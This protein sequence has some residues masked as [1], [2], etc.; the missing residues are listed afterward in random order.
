MNDVNFALDLYSVI[1]SLLIILSIRKEEKNLSPLNKNLIYMIIANAMVL[2]IDMIIFSC[3][4]NPSLRILVYILV[5]FDYF[6]GFTTGLMF[7]SYLVTY[8]KIKNGQNR[9]QPWVGPTVL[10]IYFSAVLSVIIS[11]FN[12]MYFTIDENSNYVRSDTFLFSHIFPVLMIVLAVVLV[13]ANK[14]VLSFKDIATLSSYA[15]MP[16]IALILQMFYHEITFVYFMNTFAFSIVH[17]NI[18]IEQSKLLRQKE[19]ELLDS[20]VQVMLSQIQPHFLYNALTAISCLC[21]KDPQKAKRATIR[22]SKYL[23]VNLD[24]VKLNRLVTFETELEHIDNYVILEK[25]RFEDEL[26][27]EYEIHSKSFMIPV[28][29]V[30]PLVENAIKYNIGKKPEL[31][32]VVIS[33]YETENYYVVSVKDNGIGFNPKKI[34]EDHKNHVGLEN[35]EQRLRSFCNGTL[36]IKS[37]LEKGTIIKLKIPKNKGV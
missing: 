25:M 35:T 29:S 6:F 5:V 8:I 12:N 1:F 31:F 34:K 16:I 11:L 23:R 24:S 9:I 30:Q 13:I 32:T 21:D 22:F 7:V 27:V 10:C 36:E 4:G 2:C 17:I 19:A 14:R 28:L 20:K 18:N 33:S 3:E 26:K 15:I 37:V